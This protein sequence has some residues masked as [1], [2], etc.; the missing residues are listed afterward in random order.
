M[1]DM[2]HRRSILRPD[3]YGANGKDDNRRE[4]DMVNML[5]EISPYTP[6]LIAFDRLALS[7]SNRSFRLSRRFTCS[8]GFKFS[9]CGQ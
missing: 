8:S 5:D 9:S 4:L 2:L 1:L 3:D 7:S 6:I